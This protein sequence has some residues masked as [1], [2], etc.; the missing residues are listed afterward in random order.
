MAL[1]SHALRRVFT[2][3]RACLQTQGS[4]D[5]ASQVLIVF[6]TGGITFAEVR[7]VRVLP[8]LT[9]SLTSHPYQAR[10]LEAISA[11]RRNLKIY[12]GMAT[13]ID[14]MHRL[15][16]MVCVCREHELPV[17]CRLPHGADEA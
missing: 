1:A 15:Q 4:Y 2:Y 11:T 16:L 17:A 8:L 13:C 9:T 10:A 5:E 12:Y 6:V 14:C 7:V 3:T